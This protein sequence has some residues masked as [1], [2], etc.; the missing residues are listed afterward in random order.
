M[1]NLGLSI[2]I[3]YPAL[4]YIMDKN[5]SDSLIPLGIG[6]SFFLG[7]V[8]L[9]ILGTIAGLILADRVDIQQPGGVTLIAIFLILLIGPML[10]IRRPSRFQAGRA[11]RAQFDGIGTIQGLR[12]AL[13][14]LLVYDDG[15]EI[16]AFY[17]RYYIPFEKIKSVTIEEGYFSKR[18]SIM[19]DIVGVPDYIRS[20][21]KEFWPLAA[22]IEKMVKSSKEPAG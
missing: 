7:L 15:I 18:L 8:L 14:R 1:S 6:A 21:Q 5:Y 4:G 16:R 13:F 2:P 10:F 17:H 11:V 19:S 20:A 9:L 3:N 12:G 22:Q